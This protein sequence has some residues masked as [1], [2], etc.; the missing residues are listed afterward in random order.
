MENNGTLR[1]NTYN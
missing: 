1:L